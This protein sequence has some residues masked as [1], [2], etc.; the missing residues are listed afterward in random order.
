MA[1]TAMAATAVAA[2]ATPRNL[3]R[4][5]ASDEALRAR[6]ARIDLPPIHK[7]A[8]VTS[9]AHAPA[10]H[11]ATD[12]LLEQLIHADAH[13]GTT[14]HAAAHKGAKIEAA[15]AATAA[16]PD[17]HRHATPTYHAAAAAHHATP[18]ARRLRLHLGQTHRLADL[19]APV[20]GEEA[21]DAA[22]AQV[23]VAKA[24]ASRVDLRVGEQRAAH[25]LQVAHT[26]LAA[27]LVHREVREGLCEAPA[28]DGPGV[29]VEFVVLARQERLEA[30]PPLRA[31]TRRQLEHLRDDECDLV[32]RRRL[33]VELLRPELGDHLH[34][35]VCK[36]RS[37]GAP[38]VAMDD[39]EFGYRLDGVGRAAAV[40]RAFGGD[41]ALPHAALSK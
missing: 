30:G 6:I 34:L 11:A 22:A 19:V 35:C 36:R 28:Q 32:L 23:A 7:H 14:A 8:H 1:A 37:F 17:H 12:D 20:R 31:L 24:A 18:A 4:T 15:A 25:T 5:H 16:S 27:C 2:T 38:L 26:Q 41:V 39:G 33:P 10:T 21:L 13:A 29:V 40:D 3:H 9:A